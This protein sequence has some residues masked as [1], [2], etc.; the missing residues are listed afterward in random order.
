MLSYFVNVY[1]FPGNRLKYQIYFSKPYE[2]IHKITSTCQVISAVFE[3]LIAIIISC[4]RISTLFKNSAETAVKSYNIRQERNII[5]NF[6]PA[7][8]SS[9]FWKPKIREIPDYQL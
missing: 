6:Q 1:I 8:S 5:S 9:G 4:V 2:I 3:F 7:P